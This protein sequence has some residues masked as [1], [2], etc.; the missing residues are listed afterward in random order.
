MKI[1][2]VLA[3]AVFASASTASFAGDVSD[4]GTADQ[5]VFVPVETAT[6]S[7]SAKYIV[8]IVACLIICSAIGSGGGS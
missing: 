2:T 6:T 5:T 4:A 1:K 8:P 7:P 3:A